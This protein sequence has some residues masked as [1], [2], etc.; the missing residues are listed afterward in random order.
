MRQWNSARL[1]P[2]PPPAAIDSLRLCQ[3]C[4]DSSGE[5]YARAPSR[6][7]SPYR[8]AS[9][10]PH[11]ENR[12]HRLRCRPAVVLAGLGHRPQGRLLSGLAGAADRRRADR[13]HHRAAA[14]A[15]ARPG[16][17]QR[18]A[19]GQA[20]SRN[21]HPG[22]HRTTGPT[23]SDAAAGKC[24]ARCRWQRRAG[25]PAGGWRRSPGTDPGPDA[26]APLPARCA[27]SRRCRRCGGAG[28]RGC[29]R[30]SRWRDPGAA[31][32][33]ARS[34]PC[35]HGSGAALALPPGAAQWSA[36]RWQHGHPIR[37]Q[38]GAVSAANPSQLILVTALRVSRPEVAGS[39][40]APQPEAPC[41]LT[42][43][44]CQ[45]D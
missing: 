12:R 42:A 3:N 20:A 6:V 40:N 15:V 13:R 41:C 18:H 2:V 27:A 39:V 25:Q 43:P 33:L 26:A 1:S 22:G 29:R 10:P 14:G 23:R 8:S 5:S 31:Q 30:Q 11:A 4:D 7:R 38:A 19:A 32:R 45:L 28:R 16:R 24:G 44:Q 34:G 9:A 35:G 36:G 17:C 21:P 37:V